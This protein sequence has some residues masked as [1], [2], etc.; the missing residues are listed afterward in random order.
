[1]TIYFG[2]RF[3]VNEKDLI[4]DEMTTVETA[5]GEVI[6]RIY[7]KNRQVVSIDQVPDHVQEAFTAVEDSRFREHSGVDFKGILRAVYK[8]IIAM[9]KVEGAST[10]TQQLAKNVFLT[11][12][13][14]WMRK[15]KEVMAALY[16]ERN[17]TK[18]EILELYLNRIYFGEGT[19]GI[20]AASRHYFQTSVSD[21]SIAQG[22]LLAG[23]PKAPNTYSPFENPEAAEERRNVVLAR[24][25]DVGSIDAAVL[26][27]MQG[28]TLA[29]E[30]D[31]DTEETWSNSY[32]DLVIQ[33]AAEKYHISR[34]ELKRGGYQIIVEMD[35]VIQKIAAEEMKNGEYI[36]GTA[37]PVEGALTITDHR[38]GA[39]AAAVGGR[40]YVHGDY[41]RVL[42][43]QPP[44]STIKPFAVYGPAL[45]MDEYD[46]YS[47]LSDERQ[48]FGEF[49]PR[50]YNDEYEGQ[51]SLYEALVES[52]NV[53]A[54][55]LLD[56]IGI[57][58]AKT[59]LDKLGLSTKDEGLAI[60][61]GG[62]SEGFTPIQMAEAYGALAQSGVK[63]DSYT[64]KQMADREG[65][66]IH[67]HTPEEVQ[68]FDAQTSWYLTE[69]LQTVV[70][71]G[72]ASSGDYP[73]ALAGKTGT[74]QDTDVW[75]AGYTPEYAGAVWMGYDS[76]EEGSRLE[77]SSA[78]PA[79]MMKRILTKVDQQQELGTAFEQP[80]GVES[81]PDPV[82]LPVIT[83]AEANL[84]LGGLATLR[85]TITWSIPEDERI[86]YRIFR[87][88]EGEDVKV[89]EVT[90]KGEF[91]IS[92]FS[93]FDETRYYIVP[94]DPLTGKEGQPSNS[95]RLNWDF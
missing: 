51:V 76:N 74:Q 58:Y 31:E 42:S 1:M 30:R 3:V 35:P 78:Y 92:A 95:V 5:D 19:Y 71:D 79:R 8:D 28:T 73:K 88:E 89:G 59:Y 50:N 21:L 86:I 70:E 55:W 77:G 84:N 53:S 24:M 33:E 10:I 90:G 72:T 61:L 83:D 27:Q 54:V 11:N 18:D 16:L 40:D 13:K 66:V 93:V 64:I 52:K 32:V 69:I 63:K 23:L 65:K 26:K 45:M 82:S 48:A 12:E 94:A 43:K 62:L 36:P 17:F 46:P 75:F 47:L 56:Q 15:T 91:R 4:L 41:N 87:E 85:G 38:T 9:K 25:Y 60:A 57:P 2:G 20:E 6:E 49:N 67:E 29:V 81:L 22:A 68:V 34:D 14:T 44:A 80:D 7:T 37:G 39:V